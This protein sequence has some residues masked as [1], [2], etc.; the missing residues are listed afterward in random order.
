MYHNEIRTTKATA[1][2]QLE[3]YVNGRIL[4]CIWL[5]FLDLVSQRYNLVAINAKMAKMATKLY[6]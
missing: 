4:K 6:L 2:K 1:A 5:P 3:V